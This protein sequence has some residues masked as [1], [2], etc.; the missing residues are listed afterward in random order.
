MKDIK[1]LR[2]LLAFAK[3]KIVA[4]TLLCSLLITGC[5]QPAVQTSSPAQSPSSAEK[6]YFPVSETGKG[7]IVYPPKT[8]EKSHSFIPRS[9]EVR[10]GYFTV[11]IFRDPISGTGKFLYRL[12]EKGTGRWCYTTASAPGLIRKYGYHVVFKP[13]QTVFKVQTHRSRHRR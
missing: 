5:D 12:E 6:T 1:P 7:S 2:V 3:V 10:P 4:M 11:Y 9:V 8:P 13:G